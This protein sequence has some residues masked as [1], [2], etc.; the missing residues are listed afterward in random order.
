MESARR[1]KQYATVCYLVPTSEQVPFSHGYDLCM[2]CGTMR[3]GCNRPFAPLEWAKCLTCSS[4][5]MGNMW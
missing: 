3:I 1:N 2:E 5:Q 4:T